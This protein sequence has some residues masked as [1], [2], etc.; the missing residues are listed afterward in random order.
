MNVTTLRSQLLRTTI[1]LL[2]MLMGE[3]NGAWATDNRP[4]NYSSNLTTY[5]GGHNK[6]QYDETWTP[7]TQIMAQTAPLVYHIVNSSG[8]SV[9]DVEVTYDSEGALSLPNRSRLERI[10]CTLSSKYYSDAAC[11]L[12]VTN[13]TLGMTDVY[14]PYTFD[15]VALKN[16][17]G[18]IFSTEENPRW[19]NLMVN[20]NKRY[21]RYLATGRIETLD[22]S[23]A[24]SNKTAENAQFAF[25]GDPYKMKV[26]NRAATGK[27]ATYDGSWVLIQNYS[28]GNSL[29]TART[30]KDHTYAFQLKLQGKGIIARQGYWNAN[31]GVG[32]IAL[33]AGNAD[34][35]VGLDNNLFV[36][37]PPIYTKYTFYVKR[38]DGTIAMVDTISVKGGTAPMVAFEKTHLKS[39][40]IPDANYKFYTL[41][42]F[43]R[44]ASAAPS[45]AAANNDYTKTELKTAIDNIGYT[46]TLK[47]GEE[48]MNIHALSPQETD[49]VVTY[50]Y[51]PLQSDIDLN[52]TTNY[53]MRINSNPNSWRYISNAEN[54]LSNLKHTW[55]EAYSGKYA[56]SAVFRFYGNDPY[57]VS[58]Y[59]QYENSNDNNRTNWAT[60]TRPSR[61]QSPKSDMKNDWYWKINNTS[62]GNGYVKTWMLLEGATTGDYYLLMLPWLNQHGA[63]YVWGLYPSAGCHAN[64]AGLYL[65]KDVTKTDDKYNTDNTYKVFKYD[66]EEVQIFIDAIDPLT[67]HVFNS[68]NEEIYTVET[69]LRKYTLPDYIPSPAG[70]LSY[71]NGTTA[72]GD[73]QTENSVVGQGINDISVKGNF[74]NTPFNVVYHVVNKQGGEAIARLEPTGTSLSMPTAITSPY[75][76]NE[77]TNYQ[78]FNSMEDAAKYSRGET[79]AST[80]ITLVSQVTDKDKNVY[81]GY[82]YDPASRPSHLPVLDASVWYQMEEKGKNG[83]YFFTSGTNNTS[84]SATNS[85]S[86]INTSPYMWGFY[87]ANNDPYDIKITNLG[88]FVSK[89]D[90]DLYFLSYSGNVTTYSSY[91]W[92]QCEMKKSDSYSCI[93]VNSPVEGWFNILTLTRNAVFGTENYVRAMWSNDPKM[94]F[95]VI[96]NNTYRASDEK[97]LMKIT[98]TDQTLFRFHLN[99]HI[100]NEEL[101]AFTSAPSNSN[102]ALAIAN[103]G[104][105]SNLWRKFCRYEFYT[106]A[107]F[108]VSSKVTTYAE[109]Y[110]NGAKSNGATDLYVKYYTTDVEGNSLL[111]FEI[112]TDYAT[113]HWYALHLQDDGYMY[114]D[115]GSSKVSHI[116]KE[117]SSVNHNY[118]FAFIGD[119]Y[120]IQIINK[121][122]GDGL[123]LGVPSGSTGEKKPWFYARATNPIIN[124]ELIDGDSYTD[125]QFRLRVHGTTDYFLYYLSE[126]RY[127]SN[128]YNDNNS[129][130]WLDELPKRKY[131]FHI[132]NNAGHEALQALNNTPLGMGDD[133]TV[134]MIPNILKSPAVESYTFWSSWTDGNAPTSQITLLPTSA[135]ENTPIDIYVRYITETDVIDLSGAAYY[136]LNVNNQYAYI[137]PSGQV[138]TTSTPRDEIDHYTWQLHANDDPYAILLNPSGNASNY[139]GTTTPTI[140]GSQLQLYDDSNVTPFALLYGNSEGCYTLAAALGAETADGNLVYMGYS[141][142]NS[143]QLL[144]GA[145]YSPTHAHLQV[146]FHPIEEGYVYHIINQKGENV[147]TYKD[148][149]EKSASY[150][151]NL[152]AS[153]RALG[154]TNF[155]YY[156]Y[157]DFDA[158][159]AAIG[160][161]KLT[162]GEVHTSLT[163]L[164]SADGINDIYVLYD[165]NISTLRSLGLDGEKLFNVQLVGTS[166]L[167]YNN[168]NATLGTETS[169]TGTETQFKN[170]FRIVAHNY[171]PYDVSLY[172]FYDNTMPLGSTNY[173]QLLTIGGAKQGFILT[174]QGT[175][176][177]PLELLVQ[178]SDQMGEQPFGYLTLDSSSN[179]CLVRDADTQHEDGAA[180]PVRIA[181]TEQTVGPYT[182]FIYDLSGVPALEGATSSP[183]GVQPDLPEYMRSPLVETYYYWTDAD[184][185]IPCSSIEGVTGKIF[186]TYTAKNP[187]D[188]EIKLDGSQ[189]YELHVNSDTQH[190]LGEQSNSERWLYANIK[191][192]YQA[193]WYM[194]KLLGTN[195]NSQYDP[196]AVKIWNLHESRNLLTGKKDNGDIDVRFEPNANYPLSDFMILGGNPGFYEIAVRRPDDITKL[197]YIYCDSAGKVRLR[198]GQGSSYT[199]KS[200]IIQTHIQPAYIYNVIN[201]NGKVAI[202]AIEPRAATGVTPPEIPAIIK[203]QA[204]TDGGFSYYDASAFTVSGDTYV[205]KDG[206]VPLSDIRDATSP[207]I[208]V[209]YTQA[210]VSSPIDLTGQKAYNIT[211]RTKDVNYVK[212]AYFS[213]NNLWAAVNVADNASV[214]TTNA[215]LWQFKGNDPYDIKVYSVAYPAK[216]ITVSNDINYES[217]YQR[218]FTFNG[219]DADPVKSF[220]LLPSLKTYTDYD[221]KLMG[222]GEATRNAYYFEMATNNRHDATTGGVNQIALGA[223]ENGGVDGEPNMLK[224]TEQKIGT[225]TYV[226]INKRGQEAIRTTV[227]GAVGLPPV[228]P[229]AIR[230]PYATNFSY[231]TEKTGGTEITSLNAETLMTDNRTIYVRDYIANTTNLD[232][233]ITG[234]KKYNLWVNGLYAKE[235]EG[236]VTAV[237]APD[238]LN[239]P[240][241]EWTITATDPYDVKLMSAS[242][243]ADIETL[244]FHEDNVANALTLSSGIGTVNRF[245][246]M[247]GQSGRLELMAATGETALGTDSQ[248]ID[249]RQFFLGRND[250]GI[251]LLGAGST[252]NHPVFLSGMAE[253]QVRLLPVKTKL[254]YHIIDLSG[255]EA[256]QYTWEATSDELS[257]ASLEVPAAIKSPLAT[258]WHYWHDYDPATGAVSNEM[259]SIPHDDDDIYVTY[260]YDTSTIDAIDLYS[261]NFYNLQIGG[262]YLT[263]ETDADTGTT[264]LMAN[265][266]DQ[267]TVAQANGSDYLW[268]FD[269]VGAND[270][271]PYAIHLVNK[272]DASQY[273][274]STFDYTSTTKST[275]GLYASSNSTAQLTYILVGTSASGPF[276]LVATSGSSITDNILAYAALDDSDTQPSLLRRNDTQTG[277]ANVQVLLSQPGNEYIYKV[278]N[279]SGQLAIQATAAGHAGEVPM[280]PAI[281]SSPMVNEFHYWQDEDFTMPMRLLPVIDGE[282][283]NVVYVTYDFDESRIMQPNLVGQKKYNMKIGGQYYAVYSGTTVTVTEVNTGASNQ[284]TT[285]YTD[286]DGKWH[287][288]GNLASGNSYTSPQIDPYDIRL[289]TLDDGMSLTA[290]SCAA[291]QNALKMAATAGEGEFQ[292]FILLDRTDGNYELMCATGDV[293]QDN[294]FAYLGRDVNNLS[295]PEL[296][297]GAIYAKDMTSIKVELVPFKYSYTYVVINNSLCESIRQKVTQE[298][299]DK[300]LIP[301]EIRTPLISIDN[302]IYYD[303]SQVNV[304]ADGQYVDVFA[305]IN[306]DNQLTLLPETDGTLVFVRYQYVPQVN[307]LD[308]GGTVKYQIYNPNGKH[309]YYMRNNGAGNFL[310]RTDNPVD[311]SSSQFLFRLENS[312]P[313]YVKIRSVQYPDYVVQN[314]YRR[315]IG[316]ET[317]PMGLAKEDYSSAEY[318]FTQRYMLLGHTDGDYRILGVTPET[319]RDSRSGSGAKEYT[320]FGINSITNNGEW[321]PKHYNL[322]TGPG[323][324]LRLVFSPATYHNYRFHLTTHIEEREYVTE[325]P[326]TAVNSVLELPESIKRK[327]CVYPHYYYYLGEDGLPRTQAQYEDNT[328]TVTRY[329]ITDAIDANGL[330]FYPLID[331]IDALT[332]DDKANTWV[333][334]YVEYEVL[335]KGHETNGVEDGIPF[336]LMATDKA[337]VNALLNNTGGWTDIFFNLSSY[338][339]L[340]EKI[341]TNGTRA[342]KDFLYFMVLNTN[343]DFSAGSQY[344]LKRKDNGRIAWLQNGAQP[345]Y[346]RDNNVNKWDYSRCA[347]A[348]REN[349]HAAFEEKSWLWAFAGDPYDLYIYNASAVIEEKYNNITEETTVTTHRE[350]LTSWHRLSST[351]VVAYTPDYTNTSPPKYSW[352]MAEGKGSNADH[353]FSL[354]AGRTDT[355]GN[356]EPTDDNGQLLYWQMKRSNRDNANEVMLQPRN[357]NF[358]ALDY[359]IQLLPYEPKKYEDVRLMIRRDDEVATYLHDH[360]SKDEEA[361]NAMT[362]GISRMYFSTE[363]RMFVAGDVIDSQDQSS[364]PFEV[365]RAFCNYT[366]YNDDFRHANE[367]YTVIEGPTRGNQKISD[368][369]GQPIYD[370]TGR[371]VYIY[372]NDNN[373]EVSP[374][375]VYASYEVTSDIFLKERPTKAQVAQMKSNNDHVYFMDFP[376]PKM[377]GNQLEGYNTG[378]HAYFDERATFQ[379]QVGTLHGVTEKMIWD[380]STNQFVGDEKKV[381]NNCQ[382][383]TTTNRMTSVPEDLKWYF[384]GDPYRVQVYN[385]N[386]EFENDKPNCTNA[387]NLARFDPT[388]SQFQF[389]VDCVHLRVPDKNITDNRKKVTFTDENGE[390]LGTIDNNH[391]GKPYYDDFYWEV[392]P[393]AT[394]V[395]DGFALRFRADNQILGYRN[396]YYYLT[397]DGLKR[398]YRQANENRRGTYD[399]NLNYR[400]HNE[401]HLSG[402]YIGYH[403]ANNDSTVIRLIQPSKVYFSAYKDNYSGNPVVKEELSEYF[404]VGET[405]YEVP[406]HL[407]RKFVEYGNLEYQKNNNSTW[408]SGSF[409]FVLDK[410]KDVAAY[411]MEDCTEHNSVVFVDGTQHRASYKFRVTYTVSDLTN[412]EEGKQVHLFT[413]DPSSPQWIDMMVGNGNWLYYDKTNVGG[414]PAVENQTTLVSNYRRAMSNGKTG[415]NNEANGWNDGLK[416]L[417]WAFIGDPYDFT[418][419]NRRRSEDGTANTDPMWLAVTKATILDYNKTEPADSVIWTTSLI[420][421]TT[422]DAATEK[423]ST[424]TAAL[425]EG[426]INTHFS[427]Q[428]TKTGSNLSQMGNSDS[429][430]FL[431]TASLK[432]AS[433]DNGAGGLIGDYSN[434]QTG[435]GIINQT[436]NYWRL[437]SKAYPNGTSNYTSYFEMVPYSLNDFDTYSNNVNAVNYSQTMADMGVKQQLLTI[438]TAVAKDND[439]ADNDCFDADVQI[440]TDQS[441]FVLRIKRENLELRYGNATES[442]P[443]SLKRYGCTYKCYLDYVDNDNRGI[444]ITDFDSNE[445]IKNGKTFRELEKESSINLLLTYVYTVQDNVSPFFTTELDAETEDYTW[446]NT[447]YQWTQYYKGTNVEVEYYEPVFDHYVY[448]AD[449]HIIDEVYRYEKKTKIVSNDPTPYYPTAYV[450]THT[451]QKPTYADEGAQSENDRQ[452]WSLIGDPYSF[453]MKNYAQFL[454]NRGATVIVEGKNVTT[455]I[456]EEE[457]QNFTL[458]IDKNGNTYLSLVDEN[459]EVIKCVSFDYSSTS[460]KN[461]TTMGTGT[462]LYDPTGNTL[463]TGGAKP[464]FLANLIKY[465]DILQYHLIIAHQ[466]SLDAEED[467]LQTLSSDDLPS[468]VTGNDPVVSGFNNVTKAEA[469]QIVKDHLLEYL[470]YQG[471]YRQ[472][473]KDYYISTYS[474]KTNVPGLLT[475]TAWETSKETDIKTLLKTTSL[476][477]IV[478]YPVADYNVSR[479]GIG[480]RPAV[481]WYMRRQFC[482]Y[483]LY[484][485]DVQRSVTDTEHPAFQV[486]DETWTGLTCTIVEG[487]T[488]SYY[489]GTITINDDYY[490]GQTYKSNDG[491]NPIPT[492]FIENDVTKQA[493]GIKWVSIFDKNQWADWDDTAKE[494]DVKETVNGVDKKQP[495]G[496]DRALALQGTILEK[497]EDCHY[498]RKV[499][500]DVV[501]EVNPEQFRFADKG[502][503]TTAWYQM[504]T[505]NKQDGLLNFTYK[506]GIGARLDHTEH[507]TNNYLWAPEG[508]PYGFVLRSRYATIN[509]TGWDDVAMTTKGE[510]PKGK[511]KTN[512][513]L[514]DNNGNTFMESNNVPGEVPMYQATYTSKANTAVGTSFNRKKVVH[515]LKGNDVATDGATNA[516]YEMFTGDYPSSFLMHPTSAWTDNDDTEFVSY[517][518]VHNTTGN[519]TSLTSASAR[520]LRGNPDANWRLFTSAEQLWPYFD[521]AGYVGGLDPAKAN[522]FA[523]KELYNRLGEYVNDPTLPREYRVLNQA[524]ELVYSGTFKDNTGAEVAE[525]DARPEPSLLPMTFESTNLV[526]MKPGYYRIRAFSQKALDIDGNDLKGDGTNEKGIVG[527]R[528]ISG[529][530]FESE[531]TDALDPNNNGGRWLHFFETDQEHSTLHTF[532]QLRD[533]IAAAG[534]N[535]DLTDH[536]AMRGNIEILPAEYDP[537]SIFQFVDATPNTEKYT[538][539][540]IHT[541]GLKLWARA[542][543]T[544]GVDATFGKTELSDNADFSSISGNEGFDDKFR[545][546]DVGGTAF[547]IRTRKYA[548]GETNGSGATL[549][550]WDDIVAE[551]IQTNYICIDP[552]HRYRITN[553]TNNEMEEIGDHYVSDGENGIQDTKWLLQP[554]GTKTA[555]PY[556]Q[557]PLRV[558]VQKGGKNAAGA[559]DSYYY[560]TLYVPFDTRLGKTVDVAFTMTMPKGETGNQSVTMQ[561][562]SQFNNMGNPQYIPATWPVVIR[563]N[564][565]GS[566]ELKNQDKS[567]YATKHYVDLYLPYDEAKSVDKSKILLKGEYLEK[568]LSEPSDL[569]QKPDNTENRVMVFG[570]PFADPHGTHEYDYTKRVGWY[571]NENWARENDNAYEADARSATDAQRDNRYVYHNKAY[572]IYNYTAPGGGAKPHI[573]AIFDE[574]DYDFEEDKDIEDTITERTPWP[575][576]VYDLSGRKVAT[577]ETPQTLRQN[578]PG[579][580][581]GVYIFGHKKVVVK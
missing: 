20:N 565:T 243:L 145:D 405:I 185:T 441:P 431:R 393:S 241:F 224:L 418:I 31:G 553:H 79:P 43:D 532:G 36:S 539:Y 401:R 440:V 107:D 348:Y 188:T 360:N 171:D 438:R 410:S 266:S 178:N 501:Y 347:E 14:I 474:T 472:H 564:N 484:Q 85:T 213:N 372:W 276:E 150:T 424:G 502:R 537:S 54:D 160:I 284:T 138:A 153:L 141:D 434:D 262:N 182:Y 244:S 453:N 57:N 39:N 419:L 378:H 357:D 246:L 181:L 250:N 155:R 41:N 295:E 114:R 232:I 86:E 455:S 220:V 551:N 379:P 380:E 7:R 149:V 94:E 516:V 252:P 233:D 336:N 447:Y 508:D 321:E 391:Y 512:N 256:I 237:T 545:L 423:T 238:H 487:N 214:L 16:A 110:L 526:N 313:Y 477:D 285:N 327:Y 245:V 550:G 26:I 50:T 511:N 122:A 481:P 270:V 324:G 341:F 37:F 384:V 120:D 175:Y 414:S 96:S 510:L 158:T 404:G 15:P 568:T 52:G 529:Y 416:G 177:S 193:R 433:P 280:L 298:S 461:L 157:T 137:N 78:F 309:R 365:R 509:G 349:D 428:M 46:Y 13:Y 351:E 11:T 552:N 59:S 470:M 6:N 555:W 454:K 366:F 383:R 288:D 62:T 412:T 394:D 48:S 263:L 267:P 92:Y 408:N 503:N 2:L 562:V 228:I 279:L 164:S 299:G 275:M 25:I 203:S 159:K 235:D 320:Y 548:I 486:A 205:L 172:S 518:M 465:A 307:G 278:Y 189:Y 340:T 168:S 460:D 71:Y 389:V 430:Y 506:D 165:L 495:S 312:D 335:P 388:E 169:I 422:Y 147:F 403:E 208:Y 219:T 154:A 374:Q 421:Q 170:L 302:F 239:V 101:T 242:A 497:L 103:S 44:V 116:S 264:S 520:T 27:C 451:D 236:G 260:Q 269:A 492:T 315:Y 292:S 142:G 152:P 240:T 166:W 121:A 400:T 541:Q 571:T 12:E 535:R 468:G 390:E 368:S 397:H 333:D 259:T 206:A 411:N 68:S 377:L 448:N 18:L 342:R 19:Y 10:G 63:Q 343:D 519:T 464:F 373:E 538:R 108:S 475:P 488:Y 561:A 345:H 118:H 9:E 167:S 504:M 578:N 73:T 229:D 329:D 525:G 524:R 22:N 471:I 45:W 572:Y 127:N 498:N 322:A 247:N 445:K 543:G 392:V 139:L 117:S 334:I 80:A 84:T 556:N 163:T 563:S 293:I 350:H 567:P 494:T 521:R 272:G 560:G 420:D 140:S 99:T 462:A 75:I 173:G 277:S 355:D 328:E 102:T 346:N 136:Q 30:G 17:T 527:P 493:Y 148:K 65:T 133:I 402:K 429:N 131:R 478:S 210:S 58:I 458:A 201:L 191:T 123:F 40:L 129:K 466:H 332:D 70:G 135:D 489:G 436:N 209:Y 479:V 202:R 186:V 112:S 156:Q 319:W 51:D 3:V 439:G 296:V 536:Q 305:P 200:T 409:P 574:E 522:T 339:K 540:S 517:Y 194:F 306:V 28:E 66:D 457:A 21:L 505:N 197:Q 29:W 143:L 81:V 382:Y 216:N 577:H 180:N 559:D 98:P 569:I 318:W 427:L 199:H 287:V 417:H 297:R 91:G 282:G 369:D 413:T 579:L 580:P 310:N 211:A 268:G 69:R 32:N 248:P 100:N 35:Y 128:Q 222:C 294:I 467:Y 507:Y 375:T 74:S 271:D 204:I 254:T 353:T 450:N 473:N 33:Y 198:M 300:P 432:Q 303:E 146:Q 476:R 449:G 119:P 105:L 528:Y 317:Y 358:T 406:R 425:V 151:V 286:N 515:S 370:E 398:E 566:V 231:Y 301:E 187:M 308:L 444:E 60:L 354:V 311:V 215:Y 483:R 367:N 253:V 480:N 281:I 234:T 176:D 344:F 530:R 558:E 192:S 290:V 56:N 212:T 230:S 184:C 469:R 218:S 482:T 407:Q 534:T 89:N 162:T 258:G 76:A 442:L 53:R 490:A 217:G 361:L 125:S 97:Y 274:G 47:S 95:V 93:I 24:E 124:Y 575:C 174:G 523:N 491:T 23:T 42:Q 456:I 437:V 111:P 459:G 314:I 126:L 49:I 5:W 1:L 183:T 387:A 549:S 87:S 273:V 109:A 104:E 547:T 363:D 362:T 399:I 570:L 415:W 554:V 304:T 82:H 83:R 251:A 64:Q 426:D 226:V 179:A 289:R 331:G 581:K 283:S 371:P 500:I 225:F 4:N 132:I 364:I 452:K 115:A 190:L 34:D 106:S 359:N 376:N 61:S 435:P 395:E 463:D 38:L 396:V 8:E 130:A 385:T 196:Y 485:R 338:E 326:T 161:Y 223:W 221:Y 88:T 544:E 255:R 207:N 257:A 443:I 72:T 513:D 249:D 499:I 291:G 573:V 533:K 514:L 113:A 496:Y 90:G 77:G 352:G 356:F 323:G 144:R 576:D 337:T 195:A 557:M 227:V 134:D 330:L 55:E 386:S 325:K 542:G 531:K 261:N 265:S 446:L 67:I 316:I 546:E 381:Y